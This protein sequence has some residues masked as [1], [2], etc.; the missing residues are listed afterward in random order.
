MKPRYVGPQR[1]GSRDDEIG[2]DV[3]DNDRCAGKR[4]Y[5]P[6]ASMAM[7]AGHRIAGRA[8]GLIGGVVGDCCLRI[9]TDPVAIVQGMRHAD[10]QKS[11]GAENRDKTP[12]RASESRKAEAATV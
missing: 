11:N 2:R 3:A 4:R 1:S 5:G 8:G 10:S 12:K 9:S 7:I 6:G